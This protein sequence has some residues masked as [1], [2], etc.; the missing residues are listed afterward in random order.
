MIRVIGRTSCV[1]TGNAIS[2]RSAKSGQRVHN[3]SF[4]VVDHT[5]ERNSRCTGDVHVSRRLAEIAA[6]VGVWLRRLTFMRPAE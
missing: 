1:R 3:D 6:F 4:P 5:C 2:F